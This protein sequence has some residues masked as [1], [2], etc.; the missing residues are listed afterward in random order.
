[1]A[2]LNKSYKCNICGNAVKVIE[3]GIGELICCGQPMAIV[4]EQAQAT[5]EAKPEMPEATAAKTPEATPVET[6]AEQASSEPAAGSTT[7]PK[8][9]EQSGENNPNI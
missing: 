9:E 2:E 1:M 3:S 8:P 6:P 4:E 5:Q 7:E